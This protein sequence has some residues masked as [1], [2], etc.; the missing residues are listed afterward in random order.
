MFQYDNLLEATLLLLDCKRTRTDKTPFKGAL[1]VITESAEY[2]NKR[3]TFLMSLKYLRSIRLI[4][5]GIEESFFPSMEE[6][7][8]TDGNLQELMQF[9]KTETE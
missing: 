6:T 8:S 1:L 9:I 7:K 3:R 2:L 4:R 5:G